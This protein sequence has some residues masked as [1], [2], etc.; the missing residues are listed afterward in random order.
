M[1]VHLGRIRET[2]HYTNWLYESPKPWHEQRTVNLLYPGKDVPIVS[3]GLV[4]VDMKW[5]SD[6]KESVVEA[7]AAEQAAAKEKTAAAALKMNSFF[8]ARKPFYRSLWEC[9]CKDSETKKI[10]MVWS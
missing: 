10:A 6:W 2:Q 8:P 1:Q 3:E 9:V 7:E 4:L 5:A